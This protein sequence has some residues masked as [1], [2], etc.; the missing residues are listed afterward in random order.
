MSQLYR[1][2]LKETV[3]RHIQIKDGIQTTLKLLPILAPEHLADL[4]AQAL[5]SRGF[6]REGQQLK[7]VDE[8]DIQICIDVESGVVTISRHYEEE[9]TLSQE[10]DVV[11]DDDIRG[12]R[13]R[14]QKAFKSALEKHLNHK[15]QALTTKITQMLEQKWV[16][17]QQTLDDVVQQAT[18]EALKLRASQLGEIID[19]D[20]NAETGEMVIRVK[21]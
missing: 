4:L 21:V 6:E 20:E 1:I 9:V 3:R 19:V 13:Q 14:A 17:I 15:E 11:I 10:Q 2:S 5:L 18:A 8:H 7:Q 16:D 12:S